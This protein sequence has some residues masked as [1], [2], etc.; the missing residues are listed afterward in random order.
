MIVLLAVGQSFWAVA[1]L[2]LAVIALLWPSSQSLSAGLSPT[3][4]LQFDAKREIESPYEI[5]EP[6][7]ESDEP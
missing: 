4:G 7:P 5:E 2:L 6:K 3:D 1:A